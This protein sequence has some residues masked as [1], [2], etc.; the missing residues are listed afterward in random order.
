[1]NYQSGK[2]LFMRTGDRIEQVLENLISNAKKYVCENGNIHLAVKQEN[3]TI[4]FS[5]FNQ[6]NTI[7]E[8]GDPP[9]F[10]QSSIGGNGRDKVVM[11]LGLAIVSQILTIYQ[12]PF[13][14]INHTDGVEFYFQF[15]IANE[16]SQS[17]PCFPFGG[18][19]FIILHGFHIKRHFYSKPAGY[20]VSTK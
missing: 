1:M 15:P 20:T 14:A 10:G 11:V 3:S 6:G 19:G 4:Y 2:L 18:R 9:K 8:Q 12:V 17:K 16:I 13:G 7:P 5:V